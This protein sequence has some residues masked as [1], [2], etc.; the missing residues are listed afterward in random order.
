MITAQ[1]ISKT[2]NVSKRDAGLWTGSKHCS[3]GYK[4]FDKRTVSDCKSI[5][6]SAQGFMTGQ[7]FGQRAYQKAYRKEENA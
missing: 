1:H 7:R 2:Y 6:D 4:S 3:K 5:F